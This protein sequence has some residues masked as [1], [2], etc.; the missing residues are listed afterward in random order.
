M[1]FT[2]F[3][4]Q[5]SP[6]EALRFLREQGAKIEGDEARWEASRLVGG[7]LL[8]RRQSIRFNFDKEW[9]SPPNWPTQLAGMA[10]YIGTF[11]ITE[12]VR[13]QIMVLIPRF[14]FSIGIVT[15][16]EIKQDD[17]ERLS[18]IRDLASHLECLI[19][20]PGT[21]RDPN[22]RAIAAANGDVDEDATIPWGPTGPP[23]PSELEADEADDDGDEESVPPSRERV[24]RR[25][26]ALIAVVARGLFEMNVTQGRTPAYSIDGLRRWAEALDLAA[27]LEPEEAEVLARPQGK[28]RAQE[29]IDGVWRVEGAA[30][31]AW[32]L[33][34]VPSP[35]Y[36][37]QVDV[38]PLL[39][40]IGFLDADRCRGILSDPSLRIGE[41]LARCAA[42]MLA[43]HWRMVDFRVQ[44]RAAKFDAVA[45]F[46][47]PFDLSWATLADGDLVLQG[48]PISA[49]DA[50]VVGLCS[51]I[52]IE[53]FRA[54]N[55]LV[56]L[57][58]IYSETPT[59]T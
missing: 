27:E 22:L 6:E 18:M 29:V 48:E 31:L 39:Q 51:S 40:A 35:R 28:L 33:N 52:S 54:A 57:D 13:R 53:R 58:A 44:P 56:G 32:A 15:E 20:T 1:P 19:F 30:M 45:I 46:G 5:S 11:A 37:I 59:D 2:L 41:E 21:L 36:D 10:N 23:S 43:Y 24:A 50:G 34:L 8:R 47:G 7:G 3:C 17:D 49:A 14:K 26:Y 9:C 16:P 42:Q 55:W 38:D 25:L 4:H 12:P